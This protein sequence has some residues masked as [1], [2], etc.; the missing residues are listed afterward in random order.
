[1]VLA[2]FLFGWDPKMG[3]IIEV[4]YP[5]NASLSND[6]INKIYMTFAY[7]E[8]YKTEELIETTYNNH[9]VLSYCDKTRV[10]KVGYEIISL[11]LEEKDKINMFKYKNL[12]L[13]LGKKLFKVEKSNRNQIFLENVSDFFEQTS[14]KKILLLGRAGTGKTSIKK[15]V[16]EGYDPKSLLYNPLEPTRGLAPTVYSWLDLKLGLFDSSGQEL[17]YLLDN[18]DDQDFQLAF[19]NTDFVV[20]LLD[21][22]NWMSNQIELIK[23]IQKVIEIIKK[24]KYNV[25][26]L[27]FFHKI[28]LFG[29]KF[30]VQAINNIKKEIHDNFE[31]PIYFTSIH[32]DFIYSLYNAFYE[33]LSKSSLETTQIQN[34][35]EEEIKDHEK[36]MFF[37]NNIN[38]SIIV[39]AMNKDFNVK[40]INLTH[41]LVAQVSQTFE[42]MTAAGKIDHL[43][44]SSY[45]NFNIILND[46]NLSKFG[47]KYLICI[48]ETLSAN[49]LIWVI[50]QIRKKLKDFY[51]LNKG[52]LNKDE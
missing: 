4:K 15:I 23:E 37:I 10:P 47:L 6:L 1:M 35:L 3:S 7:S 20:Y 51:F 52:N 31:L 12:I 49:K 28:D 13:D 40:I 50:G 21:Y 25:Q 38:N 2:A 19:E 17:G 11:I 48:S 41:K 43:I 46:T 26:L 14:S 5:E 8:D 9:T 18:E 45:E 34:I 30:D 33:L 42:D 44:L 32:P 16:F 29:K 27:L 24:K 22:T 39:Q 36:T